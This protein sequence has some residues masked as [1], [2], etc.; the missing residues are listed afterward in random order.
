MSL[1]DTKVFETAARMLGKGSLSNASASVFAKAT[2]ETD[3]LYAATPASIKNLTETS[4]LQRA[5]EGD[6]VAGALV[7][8][9]TNAVAVNHAR[10]DKED[11]AKEFMLEQL[12]REAAQLSDEWWQ[13]QL[14]GMRDLVELMR[15]HLAELKAKIEEADK[16]I[17]FYQRSHDGAKSGFEFLKENG[18]L[19]RTVDGKL[20]NKE[21]QRMLEAYLARLPAGAERPQT[22]SAI[23]AAIHIQQEYEETHFIAPNVMKKKEYETEVETSEAQLTLAEQYI[24]DMEKVKAMPDGPEKDAARI[25][26][27]T[28]A[29]KNL[30]VWIEIQK[31]YAHDPAIKKLMNQ[32]DREGQDPVSSSVENTAEFNDF[33]SGLEKQPPAIKGPLAPSGG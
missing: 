31:K 6:E 5:L 14:E 13:E 1:R 15:Q 18:Y 17:T 27:L 8:N 28:N 20:A 2:E 3:N 23:A 10:K 12:H 9:R 24:R 21:M 32:I 26:I 11:N 7:A 4:L 22:D 29:S 16:I 33:M 30:E 25:E 19:E